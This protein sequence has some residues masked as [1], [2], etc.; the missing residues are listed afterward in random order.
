MNR[1]SFIG[2]SL[3]AAAA[4]S[5][6]ASLAQTSALKLRVAANANDTF[7]APF[8]AQDEGFFTQNRLDV[9]LQTMV[10]GATITPAVLSGAVDI[11]VA[12]PVTI[13]NAYLRGLPLVIIAA[14]SISLPNAP[15]IRLCVAKT[16]T[17]KT[18]KDVEG[19]TV[20]INAL[21]VGLDLQLHAWMAENGA[22]FSKARIVEVPF[23]EMGAALDRGT[24]DAAV[25]AEPGYTVAL[26][27]FGVQTL[28]ALDSAVGVPYLT[29]SWFTTRDFAAQHPEHVAR[30]QRAI[31]AAQHWAN[32]HKPESAVIVS[33]YAKLDLALVRSMTRCVWAEQLRPADIQAYLDVAVKY[34]GLPRPVS[35]TSFIYTS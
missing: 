23:S 9:E 15:A 1:S 26:K 11:G 13:A 17:I 3:S 32:T 7:A 33:K 22:D 2:M 30:Y 19:K 16:S 12:V 29:S 27:Q 10:S 28:V 24:A 35:A 21:G 20:A 25:M 18:A 4:V 31:Y 5:P 34:G 14:G 6:R 8:Y